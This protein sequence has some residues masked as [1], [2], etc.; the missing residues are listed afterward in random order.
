ML[1]VARPATVASSRRRPRGSWWLSSPVLLVLAPRWWPLVAI[2][3][4]A[5]WG[6]SVLVRRRTEARRAA[7]T[8]TRVVDVCDLLAAELAAGQPPLPALERAAAEWPPLAPVA[9]AHAMGTDVADA[10]RRVADEPGAGRL[11][12]VAAA[13]QVSQRLGHG[14]AGAV[15]QVADDLR[16][17]ASS[18]RVVRGELASARATARLVAVLPLGA[19][20]MGSGVG[21]DPWSFLLTTPFGLLALAAG[22]AL[23]WLGLW[24]IDR[25]AAE[26]EEAA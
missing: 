5:A 17:K 24:W 3:A 2:A 22:L 7:A 12:Q 19:L 6:G 8:A 15:G 10:F 13:W 18:E 21:G 14:L 23:G 9:H 26:A 4:A 11:R 16:A 20:A 1:A 25:I